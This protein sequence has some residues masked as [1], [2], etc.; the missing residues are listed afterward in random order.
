VPPP[1]SEKG[2]GTVL[3]GGVFDLLHVGH[4]RLLTRARAL[5]DRLIVAVQHDDAVTAVPGKHPPI[6]T[7]DQRCEMVAAL[8]CVDQV[9]TY[10]S[11]T[12]GAII[13]Q[14]RPDIL[15][16]G[17]D[18]HTQT[19]RS[20]VLAA[21]DDIGAQLVLLPRTPGVSTSQLREKVSATSHTP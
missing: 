13:H 10:M 21:L 18:W 17:D 1:R 6:Q 16:H 8:R 5:G 11:G 20:L 2:G 15:V 19:D 3:T 9:V 12:D 14:I 7:I 4:V